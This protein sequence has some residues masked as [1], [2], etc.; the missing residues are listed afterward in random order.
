MDST[1][2]L[3][4]CYYFQEKVERFWALNQISIVSNS[5]NE[6]QYI[7][8]VKRE[9]QSNPKF[10]LEIAKYPEDF[11]LP[12][13]ISPHRFGYV[14]NQIYGIG[15]NGSIYLWDTRS[16]LGFKEEINNK[17]KFNDIHLGK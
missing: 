10:T 17:E 16:S 14:N 2:K 13:G 6:H 1:R 15:S 4:Q 11:L 8:L 12:G 9:T 3:T 5:A 7:G